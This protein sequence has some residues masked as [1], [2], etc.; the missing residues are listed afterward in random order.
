MNFDI[1]PE[2]RWRFGYL[3]FWVVV[4]LIVVGIVVI[5]KRAKLI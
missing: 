4:A 3:L 2:L 5:S 1:L